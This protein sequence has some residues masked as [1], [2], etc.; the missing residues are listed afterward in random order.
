[1]FNFTK[2]DRIEK[3]RILHLDQLCSEVFSF[4]L[5]PLVPVGNNSAERSKQTHIGL[6][7]DHDDHP[8]DHR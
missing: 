7:I 2:Q 5:K 6:N 1:M 3:M 4:G 8:Q